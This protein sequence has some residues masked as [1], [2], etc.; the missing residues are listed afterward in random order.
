M[1]LIVNISPQAYSSQARLEPTQVAQKVT[2]D[3]E[4]KFLKIV[5]WR[6]MLADRPMPM[7]GWM[8]ILQRSKLEC[9]ITIVD[10]HANN[11]RSSLL[12]QFFSY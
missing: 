9:Y 3:E 4:K 10:S 11:K 8:S 2:N 1:L 12:G 5:T 6:R 7:V